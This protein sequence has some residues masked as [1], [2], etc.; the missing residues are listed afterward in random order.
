M[1]NDFKTMF[2]GVMSL[3]GNI[4]DE[5]KGIKVP[6]FKQA[7]VPKP[8]MPVENVTPPSLLNLGGVSALTPSRGSVP[9][10][11]SGRVPNPNSGIGPNPNDPSVDTIDQIATTFAGNNGVARTPIVNNTR[12]LEEIGQ[13]APQSL[14][15]T[16]PTQIP[17][18]ASIP[19]RY[20]APRDFT[21]NVRDYISD[22][23]SSGSE[24]LTGGNFGSPFEI[25]QTVRA[26]GS[27]FMDIA[28]VP[29][30][31]LYNLTADVT[32]GARNLAS[33]LFGGEET[34]PDEE[35]RYDT[36]SEF[37]DPVSEVPEAELV[38]LAPEV[39]EV[40]PVVPVTADEADASAVEIGADNAAVVDAEIAK[41][42]TEDPN[43]L[44]K[45]WSGIKDTVK[46]GFEDPALRRSLF[47]YAASRAM[48]YDGATLAVQVLENEWKKEAAT[49]KADA[50]NTIAF[51]KSEATRIAKA[52]DAASFDY[53]NGT[54]IYDSISKTNIKGTWSKDGQTFNPNDASILAGEDGVPVP[55]VNAAALM[56]MQ[57]GRYSSGRGETRPEAL[58]KYRESGSVTLVQLKND[59][60]KE[61]DAN[62]DM[63]P[64]EK[65]QRLARINAGTQ[66]H[67]ME[68]ALV[69]I[70]AR[71]PD[72]DLNTP[73]GRTVFNRSAAKWIDALASGT[74][75]GSQDFV[76]F[77]NREIMEKRM[78][79]SGDLRS[80]VFKVHGTDLDSG[81][82]AYTTTASQIK[83]IATGDKGDKAA[84]VWILALNGYETTS[85]L[86]GSSFKPRWEEASEESEGSGP[87]EMMSP[88]LAWLQSLSPPELKAMVDRQRLL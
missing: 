62:E 75:N 38:P 6:E 33:G 35:F 58:E 51:G 74:A 83:Q 42:D 10:P 46:D 30:K 77:Y 44:Q 49:A 60:Q 20:E 61:Y 87:S 11:N 5:E 43:F 47:A 4:D 78:L 71:Y 86:V 73:A 57:G 41:G 31:G 24:R 50:A 14:T 66:P 76:G 21:G 82:N 28:N 84:D 80:D 55:S 22:A 1:A 40:E 27:Q 15:S 23:V 19:G 7:E 67:V 45:L 3:I 12:T 8:P 48:G 79:V 64:T 72:A 9:N 52:R 88:E 81:M 2:D 53:S 59:K 63:D 54:E 25:G 29:V 18:E 36:L 69:A 56:Q 65:G 13:E 39:I 17:R 32:G 16:G 70:Q 34:N 85:K 68:E 37:K 26:S